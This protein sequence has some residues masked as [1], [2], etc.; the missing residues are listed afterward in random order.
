[1]EKVSSPSK[2]LTFFQDWKKVTGTQEQSGTWE[3]NACTINANVNYKIYWAE[4]SYK[5]NPQK[6]IISIEKSTEKE[7][8]KIRGGMTS[9][10]F[11]LNVS[12]QFIETSDKE[13]GKG[14]YVA[15]KWS[16]FDPDLI[17][18]FLLR[19]NAD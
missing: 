17:Y 16:K 15:N 6:Y 14:S 10:K 11:S 8:W 2:L 4:M 12:F 9:K 13:T 1:M 3:N 18:P 7:T 5:E 19:K